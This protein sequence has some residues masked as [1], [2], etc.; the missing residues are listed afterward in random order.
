[1]KTI[2]N[3]LLAIA[4]LT[5]LN[6]STANAVMFASTDDPTFNTTCPGGELANCGWELQGTWGGF[7][8]TPIAPQYFAAA[9]HVGGS[10]GQA[11]TIGGVTYHTVAYFDC[12]NSDLRIWKVDG[13]FANYAQLYSGSDELGK[14]L[15][16]FGRGTQSGDPIYSAQVTTNY[17]VTTVNLKDAGLKHKDAKE[18]ADADPMID[19]N[20]Q[21]LIVTDYTVETNYVVAGWKWGKSDGVMRWGENQVVATGDFLVG[22][23][24]PQLGVNVGQLSSG[25]SSGAVFMQEN[26]VWKLAGINYGVDGPFSTSPDEPSFY[27]SLVDES[28]LY[29]GSYQYPCDGTPKPSRF[30]ATR[31]STKLDWILSVINQ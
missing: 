6:V 26:G 2:C 30:F 3:T 24:N 19:L 27:A 14:P 22:E 10:I 17:S 4:A 28:G 12:P 15:V 16:V 25:D 31:I 20:G 23:F 9:Q 11:F 29:S 5:S 8:G 21:N 18:I 7:L 1:M 13:T